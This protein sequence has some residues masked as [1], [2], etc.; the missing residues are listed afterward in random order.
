MEGFWAWVGF[1]LAVS[2]IMLSYGGCTLM[3]NIGEAKLVEAHT[4]SNLVSLYLGITTNSFYR[5]NATP[6]KIVHLSK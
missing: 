6:K 2:F 1:G 5:F 3:E 4:N